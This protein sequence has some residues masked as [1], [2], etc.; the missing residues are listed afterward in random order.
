MVKP[1]LR[2]VAVAA[3]AG[4]IVFRGSRVWLRAQSVTFSSGSTG[5][6]GPLLVPPSGVTLQ[7]PDS[8]V[9]NYTSVAIGGPLSFT[10]NPRNTPV[11]MLAQS[12]V[13]LGSAAVVFLNGGVFQNPA[14]PGPGGFA[15]GMPQQNGLGPGGG[16]GTAVDP[17]GALGTWVGPLS[18]VP[19]I[20]GSGGG[21]GTQG[22]G[23]GGGGAIVIA[24]STQVRCDGKILATGSTGLNSV[25]GGPGGGAGGAI[26]IVANAFSGACLLDARGASVDQ[27]GLVVVSDVGLA[28]AGMI[29]IE[30][31]SINY[32]GASRPAAV[33]APIN[34]AIFPGSAAPTLSFISI[35]G[36]AINPGVGDQP[37]GV[38]VVL[39]HSLPDPVAVAVQATNIPVGTQVLL[40]TSGASGVS[41]SGGTLA[42]TLAQSTATLQVAGLTRTPN[43]PTTLFVF[44]TFDVPPAAPAPNP[45]GPNQVARVRLQAA[46]GHATTMSF[47]RR[48]G[49][50]IDRAQVPQSLLAYYGQSI[51]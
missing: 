37:G 35:G 5:A 22:V 51:R 16:A 28:N 38:N 42:G 2:T 32:T 27:S 20:G 19:A 48:D 3:M 49:T 26:R 29:R 13:V 45:P 21:G 12:D 23:G 41:F 36:V 31:N 24:S 6:D 9:F 11:I 8:G 15:G 44:A 30:A 33:L 47:L 39:P 4:L 40:N 43:V 18:L 10:P 46:P 25:F 14:V 34:P 1:S 17:N 50:E 7:V